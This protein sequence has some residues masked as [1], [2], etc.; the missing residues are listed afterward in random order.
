MNKIILSTLLKTWI[1][2]L[3]G[4][5]AV[6]NGYT[7]D[8]DKVLEGVKEFYEK[9]EKSDKVLIITEERKNINLRLLNS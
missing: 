2:D 7:L 4:T 3:D 1:L 6:H 8:G 5:L 9:L